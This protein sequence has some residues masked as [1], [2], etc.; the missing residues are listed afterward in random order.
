MDHNVVFPLGCGGQQNKQCKKCTYVAGNLDSHVLE[1]CNP[2]VLVLVL[3]LVL[4]GRPS[5]GA[6]GSKKMVLL[7][8]LF[9]IRH[10]RN[11]EE[12]HGEMMM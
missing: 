8:Y 5:A 12:K 6:R 11:Y 2:I 7:A 1:E 4:V 9:S 10:S 3:T